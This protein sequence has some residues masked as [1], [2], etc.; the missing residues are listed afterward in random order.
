MSPLIATA[1]IDTNDID[2][3]EQ[4]ERHYAES[5]RTGTFFQ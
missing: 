4:R 3:G 2:G 5:G 1:P